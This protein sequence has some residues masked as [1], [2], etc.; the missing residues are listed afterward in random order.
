MSPVCVCE[1]AG[2]KM[3]KQ[4]ISLVCVTMLT[5]SVAVAGPKGAIRGFR[6]GATSGSDNF[7]SRNVTPTPDGSSVKNT[8][9]RTGT[10]QD[11]GFNP[12]SKSPIDS[13]KGNPG[14][15]STPGTPPAANAPVP[16]QTAPGFFGGG[17]FGSS[18]FSWAFLGY[19]LGRNQQPAHA[20][21]SETGAEEKNKRDPVVTEVQKK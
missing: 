1:K 3:R 18:W 16:H 6:G 17:G 4:I 20:K 9:G 10:I 8:S 2:H 12:S 21:P 7:K 11:L 13:L 15:S 19:L 5:S 14:T